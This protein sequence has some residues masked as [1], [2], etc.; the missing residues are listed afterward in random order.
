MVR[1]FS[2][3]L[4]KVGR[5]LPSPDS[6]STSHRSHWSI[7]PS[8]HSPAPVV[9]SRQ[10]RDKTPE[11]ASRQRLR[12]AH[13]T[14]QRER[15]LAGPPHA[16]SQVGLVEPRLQPRGVQ[17][18]CQFL[19]SRLVGLVVAQENIVAAR[20]REDSEQADGNRSPASRLTAHPILGSAGTE[21]QPSSL[22]F[23]C[24]ETTFLGR[25]HGKPMRSGWRHS[26]SS[27]SAN[28]GS[29]RPTNSC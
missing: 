20:H 17:P 27:N 25:R 21:R 6:A 5:D 16:T 23:A 2:D 14:L 12:S 4:R 8:S 11:F 15:N 29:F 18:I 1:G 22:R 26:S 28:P 24:D 10:C 9:A 7:Q 13:A 19:N 3:I